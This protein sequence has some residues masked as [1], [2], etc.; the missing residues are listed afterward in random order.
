MD[1][2]GKTVFV[3]GA[4]SGIGRGVAQAFLN[5]EANVA[6][7]DINK[8]GLQTFLDENRAD[9]SR[10]MAV[11]MDITDSKEVDIAV[12]KVIEWSGKIDVLVNSAGIYR[13]AMLVEMTDEFWD[14]TQKTNMDG[15]FYCCRSIAR[16]MIKKKCGRIINLASIAGQRGSVANSHYSATKRA[17]EGFSKSIA[18]ELA[19]YN[20]SVNCIAPGIILTP[21]FS[22]DILRERGEEWLKTI[23]QGRFGTPEDIAKAVMFLASEYADY[24]TGATLDVNGGMYMR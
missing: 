1:F 21:I 4:A 6:A 8:N 12:A 13:Q 14:R 17:I 10:I 22:E 24:I 15:T 16:E 7:I 2:T 5:K 20:I 19:P 11:A 23:P 18:L 9:F 3:T